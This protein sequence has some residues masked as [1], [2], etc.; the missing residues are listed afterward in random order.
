MTICRKLEG[1]LPSYRLEGTVLTLK[2]TFSLDIADLM[3]DEP[4]R[5]FISEDES[6]RL[7]IGSARRYVAEL[8][9][10]ARQYVTEKLGFVDDH[11]YPALRRRELPPSA[12]GA[13]LTLWPEEE[14]K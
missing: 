6:G 5:L 13:V 11:G 7:L 3:H 1:P 14:F 9:L 12:D 10:P 8:E 4:V 2:N